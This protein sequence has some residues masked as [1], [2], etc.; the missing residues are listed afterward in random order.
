[1]QTRL[2]TTGVIT[3][4]M[5]V[6]ADCDKTS[7]LEQNMAKS[8]IDDAFAEEMHRPRVRIYQGEGRMALLSSLLRLGR[9][10]KES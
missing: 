10:I 1:M 3:T 4:D 6:G 7:M 5:W 8:I 9:D 2:D